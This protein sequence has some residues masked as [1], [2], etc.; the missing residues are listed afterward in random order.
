MC[1]SLPE[2]RPLF[3]KSIDV[4]GFKSF[5]RPVRL[6]L[7]PGITALVGPN[8]S[9]KSNIVDAL[10]WAIGEQNMRDLRGQRSEDVIHAGPR[11]TL[12]LA[13]VTLTFD[14]SGEDGG[15]PELAVA[16]RLYRSGESE[17]LVQGRKGRLRD[18]QDTLRGIGVAGADTIVVNQGMADA[19]L[20]ATPQERRLVLEQAAGLAG[21]RVRREEARH[22]LQATAQNVQTMEI[23]LA[24]ME[25]RLRILR[26]QS[27]AVRDREEAKTA[28]DQALE[29]WYAMRW[30]DICRRHS[31]LVL[32][33]RKQEELRALLVNE[34]RELEDA[35]EVAFS[36]ER[37]WRRRL[38]VVQSGVHSTQRELDAARFRL[39][40]AEE[41]LAAAT[42]GIE[43]AKWQQREL[44]QSLAMARSRRAEA[45][46]GCAALREEREALCSQV[47]AR[48][49]GAPETAERL[50]PLEAA[51]RA[52]SDEERAAELA[53]GRLTASR[54][55]LREQLASDRERIRDLVA[56]AA[57]LERRRKELENTRRSRVRALRDA[58]ARAET[59]QQEFSRATAAREGARTRVERV[60]R[61][62]RRLRER[63]SDLARR[64][65]AAGRT[66]R[67]TAEGT[68][69][70]LVEGLQV[71]AGWE[72]AVAAAAGGWPRGAAHTASGP[73]G[74][75]SFL[76]W[77]RQLAIPEDGTIWAETLVE[78]T[79]SELTPLHSALV[80][81]DLEAARSLWARLAPRPAHLIGS[82]PIQIVTRAGD[83][84]SA[85]G[86][87][88]PGAAETN[89]LHL[90][91]RRELRELEAQLDR[92]AGRLERAAAEL[93][94]SRERLAGRDEELRARERERQETHERRDDA[95]RAA[96]DA[97][98]ALAALLAEPEAVR[99]TS[100]A[101]EHSV[102]AAERE[103]EAAAAEEQVIMARVD[104]AHGRLADAQGARDQE[105]GR[106]E[107]SQRQVRD[108][109]QR[110]E[111]LCTREASET[112]G[113][114]ALTE[115]VERL[116]RE[117]E[118]VS[119]STTGLREEIEQRSAFIEQERARAAE[120]ASVL[121]DQQAALARVQGE[122]PE[123]T[124]GRAGV[125]SIRAKLVDQVRQH[126]RALAQLSQCED[127][128]DR[129]RIEIL[130]ELQRAP[131][132]LAMTLDAVPTPDE[133]RKLRM[134]ANQYPDA[135]M[136]V[137]EECREL[138]E[139]YRDLRTHVEGLND[140]ARELDAVIATA[141]QEMRSRFDTAFAALDEEFCRVFQ[142]MLQGGE[143]RLEQTEDGGIGV[144]GQLPGRRARASASF[145]GGEKALVASSLLFGILR[146]RPMPF[147][148]LDEVD[149][150]LD[151]SNVDRY[152]AALRDIS[153]RTQVVIVTHNRATME[154]ADVLYGVTMDDEGVSQLLSLRLDTYAAAG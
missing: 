37:E 132:L 5:A 17:Y 88:D 8:G 1:H 93:H 26:R 117:A 59:T 92:L 81:E 36:A 53:A 47:D 4:A 40:G 84:V 70:A 45:A 33:S 71:R 147:V 143:A 56:R 150:A 25:P 140:A 91:S 74:L 129:L 68:R 104:R 48:R 95:L 86:K 52:A 13:E 138:E 9:G 83:V 135:D 149:A 126:E 76:E 61:I 90:R 15:T 107:A 77:R 97:E 110:F 101:L 49:D 105:L 34:V 111:L 153:E 41:Q 114:D 152:V 12:G 131:E 10:R 102:A 11:R 100:Q 134:R 113:L 60:E 119:A 50:S 80:A 75:S 115:H 73:E 23:I 30:A 18:V 137:I 39:G 130:Q 118:G 136:D 128:R 108:L 94:S 78:P 69:S 85:L 124:F 54:N 24:E 57:E 133:I 16:R 2:P 72:A 28:L 46:T 106:I 55:A 127:E 20:T 122:Q 99:H 58:G 67:A 98:A 43:Q 21:Y 123:I 35:A 14:L 6:E 19:L 66:T 89:A 103:V 29:R 79:P 87:A 125:E 22:K 146:L 121:A 154:A 7:P 31:Q 42:R 3:L 142:V 64:R 120:F 27:R 51:V 96:Q 82:P 32:E 151:E 141:D 38:D 116:E 62:S 148:V 144:R 112:R 139:R 65:E 44:E 145:S 63:Q 109:E